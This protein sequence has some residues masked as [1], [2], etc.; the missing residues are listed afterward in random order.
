M[1]SAREFCCLDLKI[2]AVDDTA[3]AA[4]SFAVD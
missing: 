3:K 2:Q 1:N 4:S